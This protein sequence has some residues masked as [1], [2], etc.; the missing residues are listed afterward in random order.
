MLPVPTCRREELSVRLWN[1]LL[2]PLTQQDLNTQWKWIHSIQ[3]VF[4][5][6]CVLLS[7]MLNESQNPSTE[8]LHIKISVRSHFYL[9]N[10]E[11]SLFNS[12]KHMSQDIQ[13]PSD[14]TSSDLVKQSLPL[15]GRKER[16]QGKEIGWGINQLHSLSPSIP[17]FVTS[18]AQE[19]I[20]LCCQCRH[21]F[22]THKN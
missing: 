22:I 10:N 15:T 8:P 18:L 19:F 6:I 9:N 20:S 2:L 11:N 4:V 21:W 3:L 17:M 14:L 16:K 5:N 1:R 12:V 13:R 7:V